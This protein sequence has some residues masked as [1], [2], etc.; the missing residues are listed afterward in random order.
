MPAPSAGAGAAG[1][2]M[3]GTSIIVRFNGGG[4]A[5]RL[6][7]HLLRQVRTKLPVARTNDNPFIPIEQ[8]PVAGFHRGGLWA[9]PPPGFARGGA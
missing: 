9:Q 4:R 2:F 8:V 3:A 1:G 6:L 7:N 5:R